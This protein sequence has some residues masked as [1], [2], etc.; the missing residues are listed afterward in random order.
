ML[1]NPATTVPHSVLYLCLFF[2]AAPVLSRYLMCC[3]CWFCL[4]WVSPD[5]H[6]ALTSRKL[7]MPSTGL[8]VSTSPGWKC[9]L[10]FLLPQE[11]LIKGGFSWYVEIQNMAAFSGCWWQFWARTHTGAPFL[12]NKLSP[13]TRNSAQFP[14]CAKEKKQGH[15][16][17]CC[18]AAVLHSGTQVSPDFFHQWFS[19][20]GFHTCS[21]VCLL[22]LKNL[23][24]LHCYS[25]C[26]KSVWKHLEIEDISW[27][28][29]HL[30]RAPHQHLQMQG[31]SQHSVPFTGLNSPSLTHKYTHELLKVLR[32]IHNLN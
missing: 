1:S 14:Q 16:H 24:Q 27:V 7:F 32:R 9:I 25:R 4:L 31:T 17:T 10:N 20:E 3:L 13:G 8:V 21:V 15:A 11:H 22:Q 18:Q 23:N 12:C 2:L 5:P 28:S 29:A 30:H 6:A 19:T 26:V